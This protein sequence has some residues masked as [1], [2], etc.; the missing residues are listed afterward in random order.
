MF[1]VVETPPDWTA[2]GVGGAMLYRR[3]V[4]VSLESWLVK[5]HYGNIYLSRLML[6]IEGPK[7]SSVYHIYDFMD[8]P[9]SP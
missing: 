3:K 8:V 7:A 9:S 4:S 1:Y 5:V 2:A 6:I